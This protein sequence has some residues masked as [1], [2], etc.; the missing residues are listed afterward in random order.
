[1]TH[2]PHAKSRIAATTMLAAG[3]LVAGA[4]GT[5]PADANADLFVA[6]AWSWKTSVPGFANN[7]PDSESARF[8]ALRN[9]Q[10][11]NGG[12]N[13]IWYGS[14]RNE[15]AALAIDE[16]EVWVTGAGPDVR[17]A[18]QKALAQLPGG[19]IAVSGCAQNSQP[20]PP[21]KVPFT[22]APPAPAQ[23]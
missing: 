13:C 4:L 7:Q 3:A 21:R 10:D 19:R 5:P 8:A 2:K 9:C 22:L 20:A 12:N 1:M 16:Y 14:F 17:I 11:V 18:E 6:L 23:Q 15:C